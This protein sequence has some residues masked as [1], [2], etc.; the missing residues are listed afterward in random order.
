MNFLISILMNTFFECRI[1][2]FSQN[3]I[4]ELKRAYEVPIL[5]KLGLG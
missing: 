5:K 2:E 1:V 3:Q 4:I